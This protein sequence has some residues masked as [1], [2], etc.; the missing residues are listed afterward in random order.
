VFNAA[1]D[2]RDLR[3]PCGFGDEKSRIDPGKNADGVA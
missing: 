1:A 3:C 2:D